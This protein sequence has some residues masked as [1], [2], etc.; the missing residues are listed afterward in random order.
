MHP[1]SSPEC[2]RIAQDLQIR[3][4][5]VESVIALLDEGNTVPF[6][7]RYRRERTGG[8]P[9]EIL[10]QIQTR[11]GFLRQLADRKITILRTIESQ[12]KLT[13][14]LRESIQKADTSRRLDDLYLPFKPKK[15]SVAAF[16]RERGLEPLALAVWHSDPAVPTL[17]D[18][19][20][21]LVA[22]E[23]ELNTEEDV[24]NG[25]IQILVEMVAETPGVRAAVRSILW[26]SGKIRSARNEK[27]PEGQGQ[28]HK[29]FFLFS[30]AVRQIPIHRVLALQ[31]AERE[32]VVKAHLE[33]DRDA[34]R[35]LAVAALA[36]HLLAVAGKM[37][38]P[39]A[40]PPEASSNAPSGSEQVAPSTPES[41]PQ[42]S[43]LQGSTGETASPESPI[44]PQSSATPAV[45]ESQSS[46]AIPPDAVPPAAPSVSLEPVGLASSPPPAPLLE[47]E[48][49]VDGVAFRSPHASFLRQI[50]EESLTKLVFPA[51]EREV[52]HELNDEAETHAAHV[53][54]KNLRSLLLQPP[55]KGQ[56]VLAIDPGFRNG[57]RLVA[58]DLD[59]SVLEH[60]AVYPFGGGP[61]RKKEKK[62]KNPQEKVLPAPAV[63]PSSSGS[64]PETVSHPTSTP[65]EVS[66]VAG[67]SAGAVDPT[68]TV[69]DGQSPESAAPSETPSPET[70]PSSDARIPPATEGAAPLV[71]PAPAVMPGAEQGGGAAE[72]APPAAL[73][74]EPAAPP[75]A[76]EPDPRVT[77]QTRMREMLD[78]HGIKLIALGNGAGCRETEDLLGDILA[79]REELAYAIVNEAGAGVYSASPLAREE[80]PNLDAQTR[81]AVS[82]GRRLQDPLAEL[83]KIEPHHIAAGLHQYDANRKEVKE[84]L[85]GVVESCVNHVG[86]DLNAAGAPLLRHVA[87]L[88]PMTAREIVDMRG[89]KGR[90]ESRSQLTE[91]AGLSPFRASQAAGFL[92]IVGGTDPL[93]GSWIH[94]ENYG[95][96]ERVLAELNA[97]PATLADPASLAELRSRLDQ[98]DPEAIGAKLEAPPGAVV[99]VFQAIDRYG[100]D[101]REELPQ[102]ILKKRSLRLQDLQ[103]GMELKGTVLNVVDFG[104]F[105]DIGLKES[106]LVHISQMAN[107]YIKSPYDLVAVN[108]V[109]TVWVLNVDQDRHRVSLSMIQPGSERKTP[110]RRPPQDRESPEGGRARGHAPHPGQGGGRPARGRPPGRRPGPAERGGETP[111]PK[112]APRP[113]LPP[114][115]RREPP[116]PKLSQDAIEGKVPLRTFSELSALFAAKTRDDRPAEKPP[117]NAPGASASAEPGNQ[118]KPRQ[119]SDAPTV[120]PDSGESSS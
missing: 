8:L 56:R 82:I 88:N 107:R 33:Y 117:E 93:D 45:P 22:P 58:L 112:P 63:V 90:F 25:L 111:P 17:D 119:P 116:R 62:P 16:A 7:A 24:R 85:E 94:P 114:R 14:D 68:P 109:V 102:P 104:A 1:I 26:E 20:P 78:R 60:G 103:P 101:P 79:D 15:R 57:C 69:A 113:P 100:H 4:V 2:S 99:E 74:S 53:L 75:P 30:E 96:A 118:E 42:E 41:V 76:P 50:L 115:K 52:R 64:P 49:M 66:P 39:P 13:D 71:S 35:N 19:I 48:A 65:V 110:E 95:L 83:V 12:G 28:E 9:E 27:V 5:Q 21:I 11:I 43:P 59:G 86:A 18:V 34:A 47:G 46:P 73:P 38:L 80:L 54:A 61:G 29:E 89:R 120:S 97:A 6:I 37:P 32:G 23:K 91:V 3:K 92:R 77:A 81:I 51:L 87:G 44:D 98:A 31:K 84:V 10:R 105:V 36:E 40:P 106:G 67:N 70:P 72:T 108:D 55:Q